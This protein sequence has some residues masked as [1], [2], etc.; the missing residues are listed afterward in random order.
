MQ[1][2]FSFMVINFVFQIK[3]IHISNMPPLFAVK[4]GSIGRVLAVYCSSDS[5]TTKCI[6]QNCV[7][8]SWKN[9]RHMVIIFLLIKMLQ[10]VS[11]ITDVHLH[12]MSGV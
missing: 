10:I 7:H 12:Y 5:E 2:K 3:Y 11:Y 8:A 6:S 1:S 4:H 9:V